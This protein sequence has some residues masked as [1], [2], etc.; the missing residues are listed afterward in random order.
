MNID[1]TLEQLSRLEYPRQ[2]DVVEGVM[3]EV[4]KR[5]YLRPVHRAPAW[6]RI[7]TVAA[8][9]VALLFVVNLALPYFRSYDEAGMGSM[10]AQANDYSSWYG[11]EEVAYNPIECLYDE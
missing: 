1:Q 6:R 3:A 4:A 10:I 9:A 5:P 7:G 8:A 11:V 2:V